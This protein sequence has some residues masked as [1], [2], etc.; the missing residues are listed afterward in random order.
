M[1][2]QQQ[3]DHLAARHAIFVTTAMHMRH[4]RDDYK[5]WRHDWGEVNRLAQDINR[6]LSLY[7][8][9]PA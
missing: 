2:T 7:P 8:G 1:P 5:G 9:S 6:L 4:P 3:L